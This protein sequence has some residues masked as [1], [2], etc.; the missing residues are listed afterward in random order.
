LHLRVESKKSIKHYQED[1]LD[2]ESKSWS[3]AFFALA[4]YR[5]GHPIKAK[6]ILK[7]TLSTALEIQ[8]YI[9]M[10]YSLLMTLFPLVDQDPSLG[11][12]VYQQVMR[13]PFL[14]K[15]QLLKDLVYQYLPDEITAIHVEP[16]ETSSE[17]REVLW[18]TA[19]KVLATWTGGAENHNH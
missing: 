9:P 5:L 14:G 6:E 19:R 18:A 15:A 1:Y 13:D 8:G 7:E 2:E 17:Y 16:V 11:A 12:E 4:E 10:V 3:Q